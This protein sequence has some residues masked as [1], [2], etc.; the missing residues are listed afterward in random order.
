MQPLQ[1]AAALPAAVAAL[2]LRQQQLK[3]LQERREY[4]ERHGQQSESEG[5]SEGTDDMD[6]EPPLLAA[7]AAATAT[8]GVERLAAAAA[9]AAEASEDEQWKEG[10][11]AQ[12]QP[13]GA[14]VFQ[15]MDS[16]L[17]EVSVHNYGLGAYL[18]ELL[19]D[20]PEA[21]RVGTAAAAA[22]ASVAANKLTGSSMRLESLAECALVLAFGQRG[23]ATASA[24]GGSAGRTVSAEQ[25]Q[26]VQQRSLALHQLVTRCLQQQEAAEESLLDMHGIVGNLLAPQLGQN[27]LADP[28]SSLQQLQQLHKQHA[29]SLGT[30]LRS[31][32]QLQAG[33]KAAVASLQ[34]ELRIAGQVLGQGVRQAVEVLVAQCWKDWQAAWDHVVQSMKLL[35]LNPPRS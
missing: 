23:Q 33:L 3:L 27:V 2:K 21:K 20:W 11:E 30:M 5:E 1:A 9:L 6:T 18:T 26:L 15:A 17:Q 34:D 8:A 4:Q 28:E 16:V 10:D 14:A 25:Q 32:R 29:A 12:Q 13:G 22:A 19:V 7:A 24:G 31:L 35:G